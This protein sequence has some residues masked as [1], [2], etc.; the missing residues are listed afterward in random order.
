[1]AGRIVVDHRG[2][3]IGTRMLRREQAYPTLGGVRSIWTHQVGEVTP[4]AMAAIL[5]E[6]EQPGDG[7]SERYVALAEIMEERDLHYAG[8]LNTRKRSVAQIGVTIE[9]VSDAGEDV[10][11][12]ELCQTFFE[13]DSIEDDLYDLLDAI[14]KGY[15][16]AEIVWDMSEGQW[17]PERLEW[18]L[19]QW[20]DFDLTTGRT[21]MLR[22]EE[23][24]W[25]D[26]LPYKFVCHFAAAKSGLPIRGGLARIAAWAWLFKRYT[27]RDWVRFA[28]AYGMPI[29]IGKFEP[30][31][32]E[33]D[34]Q[35]LW[36][37]VAN[38]VPD[39]AAIIPASMEIEFEGERSVQGRS[40]I[41]KDLVGYID[42]QLSIVVLGQ[43][44]TTE[45]GDRGARSL[46]EVHEL[47]RKDIEHSDGRQLS[48]TLRR[49]LIMPMVALNR[50]ERR[51]YP[52][53]VI[54]REAAPDR[55]LISEVLAA[56][57][58]MGLRVKADEVRQIMGF[59]M[60][61]D[62]DEVLEAPA[63]PP[64]P[65]GDGPPG[66][67]PAAARALMLA[68]AQARPRAVDDAIDLAVAQA[69]GNWQPLMDPVIEPVLAAARDALADGGSLQSFRERVPELFDRM[70]D[71]S[72]ARLLHHL[73]FSAELSG[74]VIPTDG[75]T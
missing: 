16:V 1:M 57:V 35:A 22:S 33:K 15:S 21:L 69:T 74:I 52:R 41:Y 18:R 54:E 28:E 31:A 59:E 3:P 14:G 58:P 29:R 61:A 63:P 73:T 43:T 7:A 11:D 48:A 37:A 50:G 34:L 39:M 13:R 70:D 25:E 5:R 75:E 6:A 51:E 71:A 38:V 56:L 66:A 67:D 47:V 62:A 44:L 42:N 49:D 20:F 24:G 53:V 19:P 32:S 17:M 2:R 55:K 4:D 36:T 45:A 46:G 30:G 9:P 27:M 65:G 68:L 60:P 12:A 10:A 40:E 8:V 64:M 23:G 72:V 26:L